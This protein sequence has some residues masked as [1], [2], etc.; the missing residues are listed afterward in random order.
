MAGRGELVEESRRAATIKRAL[1][2]TSDDVL[3]PDA[4]KD[5][6]LQRAWRTA[7]V[8]GGSSGRTSHATR[9][10][11]RCCRAETFPAVSGFSL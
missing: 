11:Q 8:S 1:K 2:L 10:S 9:L 7:D 6:L 3:G 5:V 4:V